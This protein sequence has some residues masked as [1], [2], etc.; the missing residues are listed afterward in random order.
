MKQVHDSVVDIHSDEHKLC[1]TVSIE[2][3]RYILLSVNT[4]HFV[5]ACFSKINFAYRPAELKAY[6]I[7]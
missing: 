2:A 4:L 6:K 7:N 1:I 3:H 5:V